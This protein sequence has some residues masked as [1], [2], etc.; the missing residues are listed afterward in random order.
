MYGCA[1]LLL[2]VFV[3]LNE[4]SCFPTGYFI[5]QEQVIYQMHS[6]CVLCTMFCIYI[7][8]KIFSFKSVR[9]KLERMSGERRTMFF[10]QLS[11]LRIVLLSLTALFDFAVYYATLEL[12]GGLCALMVL[13][14]AVLCWP[15]EISV[16]KD[17]NNDRV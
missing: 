11:Y 1:A 17:E 5:G 4:I 3:I 14:S 9:T 15:V 2:T 13:M 6:I 10:R 12:T 16:G 7:S 8:L